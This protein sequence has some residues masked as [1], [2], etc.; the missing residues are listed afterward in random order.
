MHIKRAFRKA[1]TCSVNH[2]TVCEQEGL[3]WNE[4]TVSEIL[5]SQVAQAEAVSVVPFT[6]P[7]EAISGAD[8]IW[9]W[10]DD[11]G[12]YGMLV[13]AKR[14]TIT[15]GKWWFGFNYASGQPK[16]SQYKLL[17]ST[18]NALGLLPVY[19]LY[20]GG[21]DYRNW[22]RCSREHQE[23]KHC[24]ICMRRSI[25]LMPALLAS[26]WAISDAKST[27]EAS[28]ALEDLWTL[29]NKSAPLWQTM[30]RQLVPELLDFLQTRQDGTYAVTRSMIDRVLRARMG[31]FFDARLDTRAPMN[32]QEYDYFKPVFD[33]LPDDLG[34]W[35]TP[36]FPHVLRPLRRI[37]PDYVLEILDDPEDFGRG[38]FLRNASDM[39]NSYPSGIAGIVVVRLSR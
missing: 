37:A 6:Q 39:T 12:A 25:S 9:W 13:Q 7:A 33:H 5:M 29:P 35:D 15:E 20:L 27:Y 2:M 17:R 30:K 32:R 18:A 8:W 23:R 19:A 10:V 1:R 28:V 26:D 24:P 34:H 4:T 22:E 11:A 14:V 16:R 38:D 36:Y 31:A 3:R 21:G